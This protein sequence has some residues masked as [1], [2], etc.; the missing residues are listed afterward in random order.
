[1]ARDCE[2]LKQGW[3]KLSDEQLKALDEWNLQR[4][5][6]LSRQE[7]ATLQPRK[8]TVSGDY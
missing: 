2:R 3:R 7:S 8:Y 1:M 4:A 6:E 5:Q